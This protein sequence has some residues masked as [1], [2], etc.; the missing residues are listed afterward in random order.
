MACKKQFSVK[1]G[2]IFEDSRL[3][4]DK[5][6][7]AIWLFTSAKNGVSSHKL[8]GSLG[9]TQKTAWFLE[10]RIRHIL[11][12][13]RNGTDASRFLQAITQTTGRR[14]TYRILMRKPLIGQEK[15]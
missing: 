5:W 6:F 2:A 9:I 4:L 15:G 13:H 14:L 8:A 3:S 1:V 7:V 11:F 12:N 10:H